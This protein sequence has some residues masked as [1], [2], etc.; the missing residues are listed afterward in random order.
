MAIV[1]IE[2]RPKGKPQRAA[3]EDYV[4]EDH[5]DHPLATFATQEQAIKWAKEHGHAHTLPASGISTTRKS[6]IIGVRLDG[7]KKKAPARG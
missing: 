4:V 1:F 5:A 6:R 2:P 7:R 3:I